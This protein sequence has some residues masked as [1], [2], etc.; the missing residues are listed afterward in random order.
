MPPQ[1]TNTVFCQHLLFSSIYS[2]IDQ[3]RQFC[4]VHV[5]LRT[6]K[7]YVWRLFYESKG[8]SN[9][10]IF[11]F[12]VWEKR[13][14]AEHWE[15]STSRALPHSARSTCTKPSLTHL[16]RNEFIFVSSHS[17]VF[18]WKEEWFWSRGTEKARE[19]K[20]MERREVL[21]ASYSACSEYRQGDK[22]LSERPG[23]VSPASSFPSHHFCLFSRLIPANQEQEKGML[24]EP[25]QLWGCFP[26]SPSAPTHSRHILQINGKK[27]LIV[28]WRLPLGKEIVRWKGEFCISTLVSSFHF[29]SF[30]KQP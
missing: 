28:P 25:F 23:S 16:I 26:L 3:A 20:Y 18:G 7:F 14:L 11:V 8:K 12:K 4:L 22:L 2:D 13:C 24:S 29:L 15:Q 9:I 5:K 21:R 17:L 10:I 19:K 1:C 27:L 30:R 6:P